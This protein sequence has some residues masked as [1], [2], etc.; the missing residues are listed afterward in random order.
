MLSHIAT[1]L[2]AV[3]ASAFAALGAVYL[4]LAAGCRRGI[5]DYYGG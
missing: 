5:E 1:V 2:L 3:A 4:L